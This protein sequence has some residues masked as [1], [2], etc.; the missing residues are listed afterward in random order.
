[1]ALDEW[2]YVEDLLSKDIEPLY[3]WNALQ[4]YPLSPESR[5][6]LMEPQPDTPG[7]PWYQLW[8][9]W[10]QVLERLRSEYDVKMINRAAD[11]DAYNYATPKWRVEVSTVDSS[12]VIRVRAH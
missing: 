3:L 10:R 2:E 8:D 9:Y 4:E 5:G 12:P 7:G 6:A 11:D 1:M